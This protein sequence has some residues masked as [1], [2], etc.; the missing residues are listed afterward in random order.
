MYANPY[1]A[2]RPDSN[3]FDLVKH[4]PRLRQTAGPDNRQKC[5]YILNSLDRPEK[6]KSYQ[7]A[8][9]IV[10]YLKG[11]AKKRVYETD[12]RVC[13]IGHSGSESGICR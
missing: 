5:C 12:H 4:T 7:K 1:T 13:T 3:R 9:K 8:V 2:G 10:L 6:K 11:C